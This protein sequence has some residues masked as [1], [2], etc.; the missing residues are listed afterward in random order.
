M[1]P[2]GLFQR[3]IKAH[4]DLAWLLCVFETRNPDIL[5]VR[6]DR[7]GT[8]VWHE[9]WHGVVESCE[10]G[11]YSHFTDEATGALRNLP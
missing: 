6:A 8:F 5:R 11:H 10:E 4:P 1:S 2:W 7:D 3:T 9:A